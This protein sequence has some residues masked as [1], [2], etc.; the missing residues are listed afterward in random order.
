MFS[1]RLTRSALALALTLGLAV[2]VSAATQ[3]KTISKTLDLP[4]GEPLRLANLAG[5]VELHAAKGNQVT[6]DAVIHAEGRNANQTQELLESM[7]WIQTTDKHDKAVWALSYPVERHRTIRYPRSHSD[8]KDPSFLDKLL[9]GLDASRTS[10]RYLGERVS[11]TSGGGAPI[12][13]AD[14]KIGVPA[15]GALR[16][17]NVVGDVEGGNLRGNLTVDTGS[18]K[19]N[20]DS[21]HGKLMVDTGSG[22]VTIGEANGRIGV[23]TGSG[24]IDVNRLVG[25]GDL[26]TGSGK[27]RVYQVEADE[28]RL[29]T[30]SGSILVRD[31][32]VGELIAD[33]S[34]GSIKVERVEI[35]TFVGDTGS[36]SVTLE[37]SLRNAR[38][39]E[40]DTGSGSVHILAGD[41]ASFDL[42][43]NQGSGRLACR[44]DDAQLKRSHGRIVGAVRGD[45]RTRIRVDTGSGSCVIEP[46]G[47]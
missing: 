35:E 34:S 19:V 23:D 40:I 15:K 10:T 44:Y 26:D 46:A 18:G 45:A 36:G 8:D 42:R 41:D 31:G 14:L 25:W 13:Y 39:V 28:L 21:F 2:T 3:Q 20:I 11:I 17:R 27:I 30:G 32:S 12:L 29:D 1:H 16:I 22:K 47:G 9:A 38:E 37:S 24:G 33:T 6:V 5:R 4:A 43:A 7:Q